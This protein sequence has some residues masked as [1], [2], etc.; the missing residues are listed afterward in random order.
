MN[1]LELDYKRLDKYIEDFRP[2]EK[3]INSGNKHM[4]YPKNSKDIPTNDVLTYRQ[5]LDTIGKKNLPKML[6][7][8]KEIDF[9]DAVTANKVARKISEITPSKNQPNRL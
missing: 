4:I 7:E 2:Y 8:I 6:M 9:D 3:F 1:K 5:I